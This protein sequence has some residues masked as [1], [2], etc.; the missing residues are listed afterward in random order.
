M[1]A[2]FFLCAHIP[3]FAE[4]AAEQTGMQLPHLYTNISIEEQTVEQKQTLFAAD[5]EALHVA[6]L[7]SLFEAAGVQV[8]SYGPYGLEAKPSIRGFT[9]ETVRVVVNGVCVNN[10]QYGTFDFTSLAPSDIEKIEIVRGAFTESVE[11]EGAVGGVIYITTKSAVQEKSVHFD[12]SAKTYFC[13]DMPLDTASLSFGFASPVSQTASVTGNVRV[14]EAQNKYSYTDFRER[15]AWRKNA[16]VYDAHE[17]FS[18]SKAFDGGAWSLGNLFYAGYKHTPGSTMQTRYGLQR[19]I[20]NTVTFSLKMPTL[21]EALDFKGSAAWLCNTR[22]FEEAGEESRHFLNTVSLTGSAELFWWQRVVPLFG[23]SISAAHLHSTNDGE[24]T[25]IFGTAKTTVRWYINDVLSL[26]VP[27]AFSFSGQNAAPIPKIALCAA[28]R[29]LDILLSA[30]RMIQFPIMDDLYWEDSGMARGNPSL[31][32]E[33][34]WG[35]ELTLNAHDIFVPFSFCVYTNYYKRKI[36]WASADG[37]WTPQNIASAFYAGVNLSFKKTFFDHLELSS[38]VEYL[39]NELLDKSNASTYKKR[40][41]YTPDVV[42][43]AAC[44]LNFAPFSCALEA[45]YMG[46]RY[47]T[48]MNISS[49]EPYFLLNAAF[50]VKTFAHITPYVRIDNILNTRYEAVPDYPMPGISVTLGLSGSW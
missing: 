7:P 23:F 5:I 22:F 28:F 34:G 33:E 48:N 37:V 46:K 8:L 41:M 6:D 19:D 36:Q 50:D 42:G 43:A 40:I 27:F 38:S 26:S 1:L 10:A 16:D 31:Q 3:L 21:L 49:L 17:S 47:Q 29:Y 44:R 4:E 24:H 20:D 30:Y 13:A 18:F 2:A 9:D 12:G 32:P 25:L 35:A 14:T 39:F 11:G 45:T 15:T